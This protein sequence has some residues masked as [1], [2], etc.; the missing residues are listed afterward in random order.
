MGDASEQPTQPHLGPL[1]RTRGALDFF[2]VL[3]RKKW[4]EV[5]TLRAMDDAVPLAL[6]FAAV[7]A[8]GG[9][10]RERAWPSRQGARPHAAQEGR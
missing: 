1:K 2:R 4:V 3:G 8:E 9:R 5:R 7:D 6:C 10:D